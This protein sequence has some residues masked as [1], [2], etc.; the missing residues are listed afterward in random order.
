MLNQNKISFTASYDHKGYLTVFDIDQKIVEKETKRI[1]EELKKNKVV[2]AEFDKQLKEKLNEIQSV[3][4]KTIKLDWKDEIA[5][6]NIDA[7]K[8]ELVN[9]LRKRRESGKDSFE[10]TPEKANKMHDD[11]AYTCCMLGYA[12]SEERRKQMLQRPKNN[13]S[14]LVE[15]LPI[16]KAKRFR[17]F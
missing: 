15:K 10:L 12:L 13:S 5:L 8:E 2:G 7:L 9:I 17:S 1:T 3:K 11:R 16:R 14:E 6:S 4:T